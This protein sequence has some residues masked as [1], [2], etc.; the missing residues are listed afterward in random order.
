MI[1]Q[2]LISVQEKIKNEF[3]LLKEVDY[4]KGYFEEGAEWTPVFPCFY[5]NVMQLNPGRPGSNK[6]LTT[7]MLMSCYIGIKIENEEQADL[8]ESI[9]KY[10][11]ELNKVDELKTSYTFDMKAGILIGYF[12]KVEAYKI[13]IAVS[14]KLV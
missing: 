1:H 13:D 4:Y 10:L 2:L 6:L 12:N 7:E 9:V 5:N 8:F 14:K 3:T 11:N